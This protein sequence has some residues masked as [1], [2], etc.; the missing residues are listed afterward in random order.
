MD[1]TVITW[2]EKNKSQA[3]KVTTVSPSHHIPEMTKSDRNTVQWL[4]GIRD[5]GAGRASDHKGVAGQ[6]VVVMV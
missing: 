2:N 6:T 1:L 4:L 5:G 3:Q